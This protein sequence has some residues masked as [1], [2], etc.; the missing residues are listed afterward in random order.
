MKFDRIKLNRWI[1]QHN[2]TLY[3]W[4]FVSTSSGGQLAVSITNIFHSVAFKIQLAFCTLYALYI[5]W[6]L[7]EH[8]INYGIDSRRYHIFGMHLVRS[9]FSTTFTYFAYEYF[10]HS[11]EHKL[12]YNFVQLSPGKTSIIRIQVPT[13]VS[14][15]LRPLRPAT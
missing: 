2:G 12:L 3:P 10:A 14:P 6:T 5:Q 11:D 9:M 4:K 13:N 1:L 8:S 7:V 15:I